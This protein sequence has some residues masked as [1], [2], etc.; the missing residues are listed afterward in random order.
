MLKTL[1]SIE[2]TTRLRKDR[3]GVGVDGGDN[4]G[5]NNEYSPQNSGQVYQ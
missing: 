3:V 5:H 1:E 4:S 2:F